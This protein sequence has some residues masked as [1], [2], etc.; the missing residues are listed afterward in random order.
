MLRIVL[1]IIAATL[2]GFFVIA[3]L[4]TVSHEIMPLPEGVEITS[5][6]SFEENMDHI[7]ILTLLLV[8]ISYIAGAFVGGG[9]AAVLLREKQI[10]AA[11]ITGVVMTIVG[12]GN[13]YL[14]SHPLW[15][16]IGTT[17]TYVPFALLG[18]NFGMRMKS[19]DIF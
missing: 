5:P 17:L 10:M 12:I 16:E 6:E 9:I 8:W 14:F 1:S 3:F 15:F 7:P 19:N 11:G 2:V 13:L 4:E 18:G